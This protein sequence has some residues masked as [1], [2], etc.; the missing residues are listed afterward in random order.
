[1]GVN[2]ADAGVPATFRMRMVG[3]VE[4]ARTK[5]PVAFAGR[6]PSFEFVDPVS[7]G[8]IVPPPAVLTEPEPVGLAAPDERV[9]A[10]EPLPDLRVVVV[11]VR[12]ALVL[13][14]RTGPPC[15]AIV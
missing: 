4:Q 13:L 3:F 7:G 15:E 5:L 1:M 9:G 10:D 14:P 8:F 2:T 12:F 11:G 6:L